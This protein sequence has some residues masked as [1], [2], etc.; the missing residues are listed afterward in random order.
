[1]HFGWPSPALPILTNG[2]YF[3][4]ISSNEASWLAVAIFPGI[5]TGAILSSLLGDNFGRKKMILSTAFPLFASWLIL[6]LA[7]NDVFVF[8]ARFLGM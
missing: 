6:G 2:T 4:S 7:R 8:F 5:V 1:M 3:F